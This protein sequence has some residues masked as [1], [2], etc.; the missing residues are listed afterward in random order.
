MFLFLIFI[1]SLISYMSMR[2]NLAKYVPASSTCEKIK[3][4]VAKKFVK[5]IAKIFIFF[6][7]YLASKIL[8][9]FFENYNFETFFHTTF[10]FIKSSGVWLNQFEAEPVLYLKCIILAKKYMAN[11]AFKHNTCTHIW[12]LLGRLVIPV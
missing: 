1:H 7:R 4:K 8:H 6:T 10:A 3:K 9:N 2:C 5:K 12:L 11:N